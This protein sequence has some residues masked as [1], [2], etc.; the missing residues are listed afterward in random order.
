[1]RLQHLK[2][3][4]VFGFVCGVL[5]T[6][7]ANGQE[8]L[9]YSIISNSTKAG[10]EVD[11]FGANG[12]VDSAFEFNDRGRGPKLAAHY[13]LGADGVPTR[14]D[15]TGND[16]LKAPVDEHFAVE[17]GKA[18]W[19]STSEDGSGAAGGFYVSANGA[20]VELAM[21]VGALARANSKTMSLLPAGEA[22]LEKLAETTVEDQGQKM[23]VVEYAITG[24]SFAPATVWLDDNLR[25][26]AFPGKWLATMREGWGGGEEKLYAL[27][28]KAGE[29]GE[30]R[31]ASGMRT[32]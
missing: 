4:V 21:L 32:K 11:T 10:S 8:V 2:M 25:L 17:N 1:M 28:Q 22:R 7:R 27:Q 12:R 23:H 24:L 5:C 30:G 18:H 9:R 31:V 13:V 16:Y 15:I 3:G 29:E 26:F 6:Q 19:K 20:G 14:T